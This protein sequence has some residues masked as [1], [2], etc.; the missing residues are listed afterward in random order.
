MI[1]RGPILASHSSD[2]VG[3]FR[4]SDLM[5]PPIPQKARIINLLGL[6][7]RPDLSPNVLEELMALYA[8][9]L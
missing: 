2:V 4:E 3:L 8:D 7:R 1:L 9:G 5:A 6:H